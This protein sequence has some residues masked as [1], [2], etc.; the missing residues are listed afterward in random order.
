MKIELLKKE[1][2][3]K[4]DAFV[5]KQKDATFY[6]QIGYKKVIEETFGHKPYYLI[7]K[8]KNRWLGVLP[9]FSIRSKLLPSCLV[10]LPF[11][12][13][14]GA[15]GQNKDIL[16]I[17]AKKILKKENLDYLMLREKKEKVENPPKR[18]TLILKL[19]K[20]EEKIW[21]KLDKKTRNL[22]RKAKKF[23]LTS[24]VGHQELDNFYRVW[25]AN[26]RDLGTPALPKKFFQNLLAEFPKAIN[27]LVICHQ[28][29]P[30]AGM[31]LVAFG[32][33]VEGLYAGSPKKYRRF[34]P[35]MLLYYQAI[36]W[37]RKNNFSCF[38]FSPSETNASHFQF[39]KQFNGEMVKVDYQIYSKK[40]DLSPTSLKESKKII[41]LRKIWQKLP[42]FLA[43]KISPLIAKDIP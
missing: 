12:G 5:N 21:Q 28:Q 20:D 22:I 40:G 26:R 4:W 18:A 23:N 31:L 43:N 29:K 17:G 42:V 16:L 7:A 19:E 30:L 9:L 35:N 24:R 14:G 33:T 25:S 6:H 15:L 1:E 8:E 41:L 39:K 13:Y 27:F 3:K 37:A 2:E 36:L 11:T 10:S 34:A 38:D 32:D